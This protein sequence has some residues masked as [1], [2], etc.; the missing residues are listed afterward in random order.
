MTNSH[1]RHSGAVAT[2][3]EPGIS[4]HNLEVPDQTAS[5]VP[6]GTTL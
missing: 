3:S 4:R 6:S 5:G 2:A 1:R